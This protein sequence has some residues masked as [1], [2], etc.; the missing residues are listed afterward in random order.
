[1]KERE[2][3][4][5]GGRGRKREREERKGGEI[6]YVRTCICVHVHILHHCTVPN[7]KNI[8]HA[9]EAGDIRGNPLNDH[10]LCTIN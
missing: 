5:E 9:S 7:V 4:R 1:M 3:E 8:P 2:R 6:S 10:A